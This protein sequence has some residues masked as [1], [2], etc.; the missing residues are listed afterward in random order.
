VYCG[1]LRF[2]DPPWKHHTQWLLNIYIFIYTYIF[3]YIYIVCFS[4]EDCC[5]QVVAMTL[6]CDVTA[7]YEIYVCKYVNTFTCK[8]HISEKKSN[9]HSR[10][11]TEA[12]SCTTAEKKKEEKYNIK[13]K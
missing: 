5:D 7:F 4:K 1:V 9:N 8:T 11:Y 13:N 3:I 2:E 12:S 10:V 6:Q